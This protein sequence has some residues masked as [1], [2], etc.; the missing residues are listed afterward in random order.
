MKIFKKIIEVFRKIVI[1][2]IFYTFPLTLLGCVIIAKYTQGNPEEFL[3]Q[4]YYDVFL[5]NIIFRPMRINITGQK[6]LTKSPKSI[7]LR[8]SKRNKEPSNI[9]KNPQN[10]L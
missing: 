2:Y 9:S 1:G 8:L 5:N 10:N 7:I 4:P 6:S 3:Q